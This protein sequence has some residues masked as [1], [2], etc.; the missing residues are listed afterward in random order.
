MASYPLGHMA[1]LPQKAHHR[2][3][4]QVRDP[5]SLAWQVRY[6]LWLWCHGRRAWYLRRDLPVDL[7]QL[8]AAWGEVEL[9]VRRDFLQKS[10]VGVRA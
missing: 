2:A 8:T 5:A 1:V 6:A 10:A 3:Q 7:G 4:T 9:L